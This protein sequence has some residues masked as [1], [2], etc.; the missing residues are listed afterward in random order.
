ML[1]GPQAAL[2]QL[3]PVNLREAASSAGLLLLVACFAL[4]SGSYDRLALFAALLLDAAILLAGAQA[5]RQLL[6]T[7]AGWTW[8][9]AAQ[10]VLLLVAAVVAM[11]AYITGAGHFHLLA[12]RQDKYWVVPSLSEPSY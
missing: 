10:P 7:K 5:L 8:C 3:L 11:Q 2:R 9:W 6:P 12:C 1:N 4:F